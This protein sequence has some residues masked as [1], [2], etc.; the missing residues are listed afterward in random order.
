[1]IKCV[2]CFDEFKRHSH[3]TNTQQQYFRRSI[4]NIK[5]NEIVFQ[6]DFA[7]NYTCE[8]QNAIQ[9]EHFMKHQIVIFKAHVTGFN[10]SQSYAVVSDDIEH[11]KYAVWTYRKKIMQHAKA[12][13]PEI[14]KSKDISDGCAQQFKNKF[15]I[16]LLPFCKEDFG[17]E[18]EHH[19]FATSHGK[20]AV[21]GVGGSLKRNVRNRVMCTP[22]LEVNNAEQ[23][24][25][26]A[27]SLCKN[28]IVFHVSPEEIQ[29]SK[30]ILD[31]RWSGLR[32]FAGI[33]NCHSFKPLPIMN[34]N[35]T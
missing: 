19:F 5:E 24:A 26:C 11:S 13:H 32:D 7:E 35:I 6:M 8:I 16:S 3:A 29:R 34:I 28:T 1:L 22:G 30:I 10:F 33:R 9:S 20:S 21:D 23:F 14:E 31:R 12:E 17:V 25:E 15:T 4:E 18:S 27:N 2:Q